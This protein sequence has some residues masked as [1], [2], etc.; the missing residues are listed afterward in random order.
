MTAVGG[1]LWLGMLLGVGAALSVGPI[2]VVIVQQAATSG[3]AAGLRVILGSATA[4]LLLLVPA[5]A[6]AW[7]IRS[8]QRAAL[9]V[10]AV[11]AL[12]LLWLAWQAARDARRLWHGGR[13]LRVDG[14]WAFWKGVAGNLANPLTWT[15][16]LATGTPAMLA[17]QR[18]GGTAGLVL[19]TAIWFLVA[20][21]LEAVIALGVARSGRLVGARGQAWMTAAS[22][23]AFLCLAVT[24]VARDVLPRLG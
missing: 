10:E 12:F 4:D 18:A 15:F 21:G 3:F 16:W 19:F 13:Q 7:V 17:A 8:L 9:W 20:S 22:A 23:V 5:F 6:F 1:V 24:L 14:R 2:F 11:G